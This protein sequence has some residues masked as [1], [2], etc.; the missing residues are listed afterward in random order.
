VDFKKY[1]GTTVAATA[2]LAFSAPIDAN[3]GSIAAN[4]SKIDLKVG[5]RVHKTLTYADDGYRDGIFQNDGLTTNTEMWLSGSGKLTESVTAGALHRWDLQNQNGGYNWDSTT[6][7]AESTAT[8]STGKYS[9]VYFKH[10][11]MGTVTI[12][13]TEPGANGTMNAHGGVFVAD[14]G[15]G[16]QQLF[17]TTGAVGASSGG[18]ISDFITYLDPGSDGNNRIVYNSPAMG[19]FSLGADV[20]QGGG[21]SVG[22]KWAGSVSGIS[23]KAGVGY[24]ADGGGANKTGGSIALSHANGIHVAVNYG[25]AEVDTDE[26]SATVTDHDT[27]RIVAGYKASMNSLG[28]TN[29]SISYLEADDVSGVGDNGESL[30]I[31]IGQAL[32]AIGSNIK[33]TYDQLSFSDAASTDLND[34]DTVSL[35]FSV[36]F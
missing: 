6:G 27:M 25:E 4:N 10:S 9:Y 29:I 31:G 33:F 14:P 5:A 23:A 32:D 30:Q 2:L 34:I 28:A 20:E 36:N 15:G 1:L 26:A 18:V 19:G 16:G 17:I 24:E 22:L 21:G 11:S 8:T 7:A 12:G 3:A 35:D 13:D